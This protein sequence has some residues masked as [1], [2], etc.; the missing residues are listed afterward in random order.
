MS[1]TF[2]IDIGHFH[3]TW[4]KTKTKGMVKNGRVIEEYNLNKLVAVNLY[5]I[6]K[7]QK[8]NVYYT[9]PFN[10]KEPENFNTRKLAIDIY[11]PALNISIHHDW[12]GSEDTRGFAIYTWRGNKTTAKIK[13]QLTQKMKTLCFESNLN[14]N[15][16][17]I[18]YPGHQNFAIIRLPKA[19]SILIEI[20][21]FSNE[22]DVDLTTN[23]HYDIAKLIAEGILNKNIEEVKKV[24]NN[25]PE[26]KIAELN[27]AYDN[28]IITDKNYWLNRI[29]DDDYIRAS[30]VLAMLNNLYE[31]LK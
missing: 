23:Y 12:S 1:N 7:K 6:L 13:E 5:E 21:Y 18:C 26:W 4:E 14:N 20:G 10:A 27:Q 31:K 19:N 15:G 2:T 8:C 29:N 11:N 16:Y 22:K 3:D 25:T 9:M 17:S 28:K 24:S 30:E